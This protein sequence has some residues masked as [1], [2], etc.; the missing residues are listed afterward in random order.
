MFAGSPSKK[1][2]KRA[3]VSLIPQP[4]MLIGKVI[5]KRIIG[6]NTKNAR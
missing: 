3:V 4:P 2:I 5:E 6:V 1:E